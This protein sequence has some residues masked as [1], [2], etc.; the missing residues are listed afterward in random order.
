MREL[1]LTVEAI[2]ER[3]MIA[4]M[5]YN[6]R[7]ALPAKNVSGPAML[8]FVEAIM[9]AAIAAHLGG[10]RPIATVD[11]TASFVAPV[12]RADIL[13]EITFLRIG[14]RLIFAAIMLHADGD[15]RPAASMT[16]TWTILES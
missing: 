1:Q 13:A 8:A 3:G 14:R 6:P 7:A 5:P 10:L 2:T 12:D 4:R 16:T 9:V 11:L 15:D